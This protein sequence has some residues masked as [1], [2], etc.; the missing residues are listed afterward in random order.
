MQTGRPLLRYFAEPDLAPPPNI[1]SRGTA[2]EPLLRE[3]AISDLRTFS[4]EFGN[5]GEAVL[6]TSNLT[7]K[8]HLATF[9]GI[10]QALGAVKVRSNDTQTTVRPSG[11]LGAHVPEIL[12][13]YL[14][15]S[16]TILENWGGTHTIPEDRVSA[17]EFLHQMELRR[18]EQERRAGRSVAPL[19]ERPVAFVIFRAKNDRGED[20]YLFEINKDWRRL[21][22]IGGKQEPQDRGDY[23]ETAR[24]EVFEE[25]GI[26]KDR[27]MLTRLNDHPIVGYSLSG[28]VG[29]LSRYPCV[30]YGVR[31]QGELKVRPHD[32]WLTE[33]AIQRSMELA[34]SPLMVNPVYL[35]FLLDGK[36]SRLSTLPLSIDR[37]IRSTPLRD[38]I[39]NG[40]TT[41]SRWLRVARENK[42]LVAAVL[43]IVAAALGVIL[44]I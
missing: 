7:R 11:R 42:D 22:F 9:I 17:L 16:F 38:I 33:T 43:T 35:S 27:L 30:L 10:C 8:T 31:V 23:L 32:K 1:T 15:R 28:N 25:L 2:A 29:S 39:P 34:D 24:R 6:A 41:T 3:D 5:A 21:N 4:D 40:E 20:C 18:I 13:T 37:Q 14:E 26:G 44:A 12:C 19:A 36:P